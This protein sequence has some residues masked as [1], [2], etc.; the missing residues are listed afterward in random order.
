MIPCAQVHPW[1]PNCTRMWIRQLVLTTYC[2][3]G[4]YAP[5]Y[6]VSTLLF[7][8]RKLT[9]KDITHRMFPDIFRSSLFLGV[10]GCVFFAFICNLRKLRQKDFKSNYFISGFFGALACISVEKK[11]RRTELTTYILNQAME[12]A[13]RVAEHYNFVK[14]RNNGEIAIFM[15]AN[16]IIMY[17]YHHETDTLRG[18]ARGIVKMVL[19]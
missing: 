14:A 4:I 17:L 3:L 2:G 19:G 13:F 12:S 11:S 15:L 8:R 16:A 9:L 1:A 7:R 18:S 6:F 5:I 10:F